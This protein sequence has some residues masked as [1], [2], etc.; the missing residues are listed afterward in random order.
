MKENFITLQNLIKS[1]SFN[2]KIESYLQQQA[3]DQLSQQRHLILQ[4]LTHTNRTKSDSFS[5]F[6]KLFGTS[7]Q[8]G[9]EQIN[10]IDDN[11]F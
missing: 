9:K 5:L 3:S 11:R 7:P 8:I 1:E 2:T 4:T 6:L 10:T